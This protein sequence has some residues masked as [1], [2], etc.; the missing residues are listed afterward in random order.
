VAFARPGKPRGH[1]FLPAKPSCG[2]VSLE[3][4]DCNGF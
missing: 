4:A 1:R 3:V 2:G